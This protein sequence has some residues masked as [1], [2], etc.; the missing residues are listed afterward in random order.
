MSGSFLRE[1]SVNVLL[2]PNFVSHL[3]E[4][5]ESLK[6]YASPEFKSIN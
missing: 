5:E 6:R 2:I 1:K 4:G 3:A